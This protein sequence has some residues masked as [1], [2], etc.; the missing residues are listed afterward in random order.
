MQISTEVNFVAIQVWPLKLVNTMA[1]YARLQKDFMILENDFH[2]W[3][4]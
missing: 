4:N 2:T 1:T 3:S